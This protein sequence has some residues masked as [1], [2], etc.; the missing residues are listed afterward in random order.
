MIVAIDFD[1]PDRSQFSLFD[2]LVTCLNQVW[3]T[4][5]LGPDL[6]DSIM[7][8]CRR[9]DCLPLDD[10]NT[11]R[12]L[13]INVRT[14]LNGSNGGQRV[15]VIGSGDQYQFWLSLLQQFAV[16]T[17]RLRTLLPLLPLRHDVGCF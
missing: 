10:I 2:D 5:T 1:Q 13:Q 4:A 8:A 17:K 15:P 11:D 7:L 3:R 9:Q 6:D 12:L 16:I 14:R